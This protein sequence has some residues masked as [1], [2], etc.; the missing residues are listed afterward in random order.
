MMVSGIYIC[1]YLMK[2][3]HP[4]AFNTIIYGG[5]MVLAVILDVAWIWSSSTKL[6][7]SK[8]IDN[9]SQ[10]GIRST[11]VFLSYMLLI[12]EVGVL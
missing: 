5:L 1:W 9:S 4:L 11:A 8:Y 12:L 6:W 10:R 3:T 2:D 7:R